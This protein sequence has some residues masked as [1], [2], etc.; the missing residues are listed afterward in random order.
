LVSFLTSRLTC[1]FLGANVSR[2]IGAGIFGGK[3]V[4]RLRKRVRDKRKKART[5]AK[6]EI[7]GAVKVRKIVKCERNVKKRKALLKYEAR[8]E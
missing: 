2:V 8:W 3:N 4:S 1:W 6:I 5:D 7:T